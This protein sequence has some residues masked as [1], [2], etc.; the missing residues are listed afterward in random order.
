[1]ATVYLAR[2]LKNDNP[3][4]IKVLS[5]DVSV[6]LGAERFRRE[7]E[8]TTLLSHP[9]ILPIYDSGMAGDSLFYVMPYVEGESLR[10]RLDRERHLSLDDAIRLTSQIGQGAFGS[11]DRGGT[12]C[13]IDNDGSIHTTWNNASVPTDILLRKGFAIPSWW[14]GALKVSVAIDNDIKVFVNGHDESASASSGFN[15]ATGFATHENCATLNSVTFIV[16]DTDLMKGS[17]NVIAIRA[18]D[19]GTIAYVDIRLSAA[20]P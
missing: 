18:R 12:V 19:R 2:D 3:V 16:P 14:S 5:T 6:V 8:V 9:N 1:M 4:A 20:T 13:P 11:G 10:A 15:P 7:I 17:T